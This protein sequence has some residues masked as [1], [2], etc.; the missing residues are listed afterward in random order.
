MSSISTSN[1]IPV[2]EVLNALYQAVN[3]LTDRL[4][5][6]DSRLAAL[7]SKPTPT[8][9]TP[10]TSTSARGPRAARSKSTKSKAS[11]PTTSSATKTPAPTTI[12]TL[13]T[14]DVQEKIT[15]TLSIPD[16]QAGHLVGRA[17]T[18][19]RQIHDISHAKLSVSPTVV[20][21]SRVVTIRGS[22]REVGD[23]TTAIGKR[24]A[25]R[26]LR[27]PRSTK[28]KTNPASSPP[29][30]EGTTK[31]S[32]SSSTPKAPMQA[33]PSGRPPL[34]TPTLPPV[35]LSSGSLSAAQHSS[36]PTVV[37]ASKFPRLAASMAGRRPKG[38]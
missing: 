32:T 28:K 15:V 12:R 25:R 26:R 31:P 38:Q 29:V 5:R 10:T 9:A 34:S 8:T 23:A 36:S 11:A 1:P 6:L 18:G 16:A 19:L 27:T 2:E 37:D 30:V 21:G 4:D 14:Q 35:E 13:S 3:L 24:L 7:E 20:S 33:K 22:T 17:G